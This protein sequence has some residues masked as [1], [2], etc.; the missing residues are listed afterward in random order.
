MLTYP[1][2]DPVILSI[3]GLKRAGGGLFI[4]DTGR[5]AVEE[6]ARGSQGIGLV[7]VGFDSSTIRC[8]P[9]AGRRSPS[10]AESS[11]S[12]AAAWAAV[13]CGPYAQ[14]VR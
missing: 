6:E 14:G 2:I 7:E 5:T 8:G 12:S 11:W 9:R 1:E 3:F 4:L 13:L 10:S